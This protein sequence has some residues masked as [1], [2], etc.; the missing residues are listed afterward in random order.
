MGKTTHQIISE[1]IESGEFDDLPGKGKPLDLRNE[2]FLDPLT[3]I[4]NRILRDNDASHPLLEARRAMQDEIER[5][6]EDL[7]LASMN[8][9]R[10]SSEQAW[11][12]A[13]REL[14]KRAKQINGHIRLFNLKAPSPVLHGLAIDVD[15]E[16]RKL[17]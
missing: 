15:A 1:A 7:R 5:W 12:D 6:R 3:S 17:G 14:R 16:M 11:Q 10:T 2:P 13:L 4:V 8:Y 9:R